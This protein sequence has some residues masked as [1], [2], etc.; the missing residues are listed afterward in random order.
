MKKYLVMLAIAITAL[1]SSFA[2][3]RAEEA[4]KAN[5]NKTVISIMHYMG[6]ETKRSGLQTFCD[7]YTASHPDV[8]FEIQ[9][10][11]YSQFGQ[12][13][14]TK[15]A[16]GDVPDIIGGRPRDFN[17]FVEAGHIQDLSGQAF[18]ENLPQDFI[19]EMSIDNK[20]YGLPLDY[21]IKG[22]FYNMDMF[23][24]YNLEVPRTFSDFVKVMDTFENAG[25]VPFARP[26][27]DTNAPETD[28]K[29][30]FSV[31]LAKQN[32]TMWVQI[33]SGEKHITDFPIFKEELTKYVKRMTYSSFDDYAMD[34]SRALQM[35]AAGEAPM[36]I[37]GAWISGDLLSLNPT[38]HFGCFPV[39]WSENAA[40]NQYE[41][42]GD[43][44]MM[45][46][47]GSKNKEIAMDFINFVGSD[48][49]GMIWM[50]KA[51]L[52]S[53][54]TNIKADENMPTLLIELSDNLAKGWGYS[55]SDVIELTGEP[56]A[57]YR[58]SLHALVGND[59][60]KAN[61]DSFISNLDKDLTTAL[62]K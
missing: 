51:K 38:G 22:V 27:K 1:S 25:Q 29:A 52:I 60:L 12:Q 45:V 20:V 62:A 44:A 37:N 59:N 33:A 58:Q 3:G 26:F 5:E 54:N 49:G 10:V 16:A 43:D 41:V 17:Q 21:S 19:N 35:F 6:E 53:T 34:G 39:P 31:T 23:E 30:S 50:E 61:L 8:V 4:S 48:E 46:A 56:K 47:Q 2:N 55:S 18:I 13:L 15:I 42:K 9:A 57:I 11:P 14:Q 7:T 36:M 32:P 28:F 24:E 40:D